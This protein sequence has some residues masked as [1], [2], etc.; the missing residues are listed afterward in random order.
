MRLEDL[1]LREM[2]R[3]AVEAGRRGIAVPSADL[4]AIARHAVSRSAAQKAIQ[5]LVRAGSV[6]RV[7]KDLLVLPDTTGLL[8]VDMTDLI[9]AVAGQPYLITAGRALAQHELTDQHFF[10]VIVLTPDRVEKL[11]YRGQ[12]ATFLQTDP[13]NIWGWGEGPGP[14]Y[15]LPERALVD[16]LNHPRYAVSLTQALDALLLAVSRDPTFASR[17]LDTVIR[18]NS[19]S[20]AR[21]VGLVVERFLGP[22]TAA[23]YRDLIGENRAPVLMRPRGNP[24]GKLDAR[25][26]VVVN[27]VL[28]PERVRS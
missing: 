28:E 24:D 25:W 18:Y 8:G 4:D 9:D 3:A 6:V 14:H 2:H 12:K 7:R 21:R 5:R 11:S 13:S 26:R 19:P 1:V 20:A 16:V 15:A 27:A 23:P 10:G 17:L 22:E